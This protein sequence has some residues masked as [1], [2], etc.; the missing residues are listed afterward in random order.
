M[1]L[2]MSGKAEVHDEPAA[3]PTQAELLAAINNNPNKGNAVPDA[4]AP[5]LTAID[6]AEVVLGEPSFT[7]YLTGEG[8]DENSVIVF[9]GQ[10]EPTTLE[11][12]GRLSTGVNMDVWHGPDA[13][14]VG[15][16][17]GS[18]MSN[19]LD[20]TFAES[21]PADGEAD[22]DY[23]EEEIDEAIEAGDAKVVHRGA[24]TKTLPTKRKR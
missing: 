14:P 4:P 23:L 24:P 19:T 21:A 10:D 17:N 2:H 15:V 12:D 9:A 1:D 22:P 20:F 13:V 8:F 6:P 18:T 7:V 11:E 3:G 16:R 5:V